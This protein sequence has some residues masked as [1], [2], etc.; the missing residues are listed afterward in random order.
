[1][2][3]SY[4]FISVYKQR[5]AILDKKLFSSQSQPGKKAARHEPGE[6]GH[7]EYRKTLSRFRQFL[8]EE[9]KFYVQLLIRFE[10]QFGLTEARSALVRAEI[11]T[12]EQEDMPPTDSGRS[13][14]PE[15]VEITPM[16]THERESRLATFTKILVCLGDI[17][18]YREQYNDGGGRPRA[19]H[20]EGQPRR[21]ARGGRKGGHE[22]VARPR[23]YNRARI[24]YEQARLLLPND[25]NASHQ[26]AILCSYQKDTFGSL[27]HYYRALC[28]RQPYDTASNNLDTVLGKALDQYS[29]SKGARG[30]DDTQAVQKVRNDKFLESVVVLHGLWY[31]DSDEYVHLLLFVICALTYH[32][33]ELRELPSTLRMLLRNSNR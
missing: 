27:L 23:N 7:V 29:A 15:H 24:I 18:R 13:L 17:A 5:L 14:F 4:Q 22:T 16:T 1:M 32:L 19:G 20:E 30:A 21:A 33:D 12:P 25:G 6:G 2:Q 10:S 31:L 8:A 26:L 11:M 3:T 28:V 9:E